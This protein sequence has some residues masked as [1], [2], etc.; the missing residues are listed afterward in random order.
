MDIVVSLV[1]V[2]H[3]NH[4]RAAYGKTNMMIEDFAENIQH[5]IER[6]MFVDWLE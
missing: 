2:S 3:L 1:C 4:F 6:L 5:I